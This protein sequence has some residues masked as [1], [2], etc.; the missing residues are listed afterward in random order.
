VKQ[1]SRD[2]AL[3][4]AKGRS[5]LP[6]GTQFAWYYWQIVVRRFPGVSWNE[7][8]DW[9]LWQVG[10]TLGLDRAEPTEEEQALIDQF[11]EAAMRGPS[12]NRKG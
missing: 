2:R 11:N 1:T 9:E 5:T 12:P 3:A 10:A 6:P 7:F 4:A 8:Q